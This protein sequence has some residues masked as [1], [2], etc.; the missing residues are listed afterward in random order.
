MATITSETTVC[1]IPQEDIGEHP[2]YRTISFG[3]DGTDWEID[4]CSRA[5]LRM[6]QE[7]EP[8]TG[9]ARRA[10]SAGKK[11]GRPLAQR[12]RSAAIRKW[13]I[14]QGLPV[15]SARGRIASSIVAKYDAE[16]EPV[17]AARRR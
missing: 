9:N 7:L 5:A 17:T 4:L 10:G 8:Y 2:A 16:H 15:S 3:I 6:R 14:E 12:R 1:D 13:A 11:P